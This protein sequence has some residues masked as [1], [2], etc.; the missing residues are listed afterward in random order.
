[1]YCTEATFAARF[2][3]EELDQ[4]TATNGGLDYADAAAA[5]DA[6]VD[7]YLAAIPGRTFPLPLTTAP[8]RVV[9]VAADLVRFELWANRS[10]EEV[11]NRRDQAVEWLKDLVAGKAAL[12]LA[13]VPEPEPQGL[14]G[15]LGYASADRVFTADTLRGFVGGG[16]CD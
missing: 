15:R 14:R 12:L 8:A 9:G 4:V 2:G 7:S 13:D 10:S 11:R 5:A 3:Q 6:L 1:M 16:P